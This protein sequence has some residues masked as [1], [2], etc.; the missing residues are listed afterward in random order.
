MK[1]VIYKSLSL[2]IYMFEK[3]ASFDLKTNEQ[4]SPEKLSSQSIK[5]RKK[6]RMKERMGKRRNLI[7]GSKKKKRKHKILLKKKA[8]NIFEGQTDRDREKK[9]KINQK[10]KWKKIHGER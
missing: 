8:C 1:K 6:E 4:M 3:V 9:M 7:D 2:L 10:K 5:E